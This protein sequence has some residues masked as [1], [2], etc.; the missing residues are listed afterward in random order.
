MASVDQWVDDPIHEGG[1]VDDSPPKMDVR[2]SIAARKAHPPAGAMG[3]PRAASPDGGTVDVMSGLTDQETNDAFIDP[4][5]PTSGE[6]AKTIAKAPVRVA[7]GALTAPFHA[8][9]DIAAAAQGVTGVPLPDWL[10]KRVDEKGQA[11]SE[12]FNEAERNPNWIQKGLRYTQAS[13]APGIGPIAGIVA[14]VI[15]PTTAAISEGR[16]PTKEEKLTSVG[17]T[18]DVEAGLVGGKV[19]GEVVGKAGDL[20]GA[21]KQRLAVTVSERVAQNLIKPKNSLL[22]FEAKP[23]KFIVGMKVTPGEDIGSLEP[24]I[25]A[26]LDDLQTK[27]DDIAQNTTEGRTIPIDYEG[28]IRSSFQKHISAA[29]MD[30]N[31]GLAERLRLVEKNEIDLLHQN[32]GGAGQAPAAVGRAYQQDLST[33]IRDFKPDPIDGTIRAARQDAWKAISKQTNEAIPAIKPIN[34][35]I[36]DGIEASQAVKEAAMNASKAPVTLKGAIADVVTGGRSNPAYVRSRVAA[37]LRG[38]VPEAPVEMPPLIQGPKAPAGLPPT[39]LPNEPLPTSPRVIRAQEL[40]TEHGLPVDHPVIGKLVDSEYDHLTGVLNKNSYLRALDTQP[41][42]AYVSEVDVAGAGATNN[43][44]EFGEGHTDAI[45]KATGEKLTELVGDK[46]TVYRKG[47]DEFVVHWNDKAYGENARISIPKALS[48]AEVVVERNGQTV[49]RWK[50]VDHYHGHGDNFEAASKEL[51]DT[52]P[53]PGTP[54]YKAIPKGFPE[55]V[56]EGTVFNTR[57]VSRPAG[58]RG[59]EG[60]TSSD[61]SSEPTA[62]GQKLLELMR[63]AREGGQ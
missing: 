61:R 12:A 54:E 51:Y 3:D 39:P 49:A 34:S 35:M 19:A 4:S 33:R 41:P 1:W 5:G 58:V 26:K 8:G 20:Y 2:S 37:G 63:K 55:R 44:P 42:P 62:G 10:Q 14:N 18:A 29:Q 9:V 22:K 50:G 52:K 38:L 43:H 57:S 27:A 25:Q 46:G 56:R 23:G 30:G 15:Q 24:Q 48:E 16:A 21:A 60:R 17:T 53:K 47:G 36:H 59:S 7:V 31:T 13:G 11:N 28:S 6:Y 40:A 45:I 32:T